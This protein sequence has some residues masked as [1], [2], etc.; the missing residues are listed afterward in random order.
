[1]DLGQAYAGIVNCGLVDKLQNCQVLRTSLYKFRRAEEE[2]C[3]WVLS[4]LG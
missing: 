4:G 2:D 3:S 1:V